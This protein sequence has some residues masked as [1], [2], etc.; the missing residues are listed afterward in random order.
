M[1]TRPKRLY[2]KSSPWHGTECAVAGSK[3]APASLS[4][5]RPGAR[6]RPSERAQQQRAEMMEA[7]LTA[8][9]MHHTKGRSCKP[10]DSNAK[11][12]QAN[13]EKVI[14]RVRRCLRRHEQ[15]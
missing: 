12:V 8:A 10:A 2:F 11:I 5:M 9:L 14:H 15:F 3:L 1:L 4:D 6:K 13:A 7:S